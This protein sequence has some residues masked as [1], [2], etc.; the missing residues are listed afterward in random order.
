MIINKEHPF[1]ISINFHKFVFLKLKTMEHLVLF[2]ICIA[3][4]LFSMFV[5][6]KTPKILLLT[7]ALIATFFLAN[8]TPIGMLWYIVS[9]IIILNIVITLNRKS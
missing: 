1:F 7:I 8:S 4:Q 6:D 9:I 2:I 5:K 3:G